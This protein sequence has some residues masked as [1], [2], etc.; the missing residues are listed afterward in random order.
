MKYV[1]VCL[2]ALSVTF[3]QTQDYFQQKVDYDITVKL[4]DDNHTLSAYEKI[5]Y[6]NNSPD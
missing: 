6:T 4:D 5:I 1:F 2:F 3:A